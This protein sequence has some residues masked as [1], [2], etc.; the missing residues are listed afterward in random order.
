MQ[1]LSAKDFYKPTPFNSET[2]NQIWMS[3]IADAHDNICN[4]NHPFAHLLA[5]IFPPGHKDR[6]LTIQQILQRDYQER[7]RSG[8][9]ADENLG[10][11]VGDAIKEDLQPERE[12]ED[13]IKDE[14]LQDII[15]A[16]EDAE[17]TR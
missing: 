7:C 17:N 8:G 10:L 2:K 11:A 5:S 16:G 1:N 14:E 4:C 3:Q 15:A 9:D 12:E 13:L 6:D